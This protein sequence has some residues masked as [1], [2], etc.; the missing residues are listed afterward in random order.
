MLKPMDTDRTSSAR[1]THAGPARQRGISPLLRS[2][3]AGA[4]RTDHLRV[5]NA[6]RQAVA[7]RL[8]EHFSDGRLSQDE[9]DERAKQAVHAKTR[10]DLNGLFDDL[11]EPGED[12]AEPRR[13]DGWWYGPGYRAAAFG[14]IVVICLAGAE[15]IVHA[16]VPWLWAG[17]LAIALLIITIRS[18]RPG[19]GG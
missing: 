9:F 15:S 5:S 3:G 2:V 12:A 1:R 18:A 14:L 8:A 11:P 17:F 19:S 4:G 16:T 6:E 13:P 7:D 10:G